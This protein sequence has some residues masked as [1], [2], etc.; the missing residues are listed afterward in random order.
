MEALASFNM[1]VLVC[2]EHVVVLVADVEHK[3]ED[4]ISIRMCTSVS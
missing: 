3:L 2:T 4:V 1:L